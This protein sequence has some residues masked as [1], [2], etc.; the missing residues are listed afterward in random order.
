MQLLPFFYLLTQLFK[1]CKPVTQFTHISTTRCET[2]Q[3][4]LLLSIEKQCGM[5]YGVELGMISKRF[6]E[7]P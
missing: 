2:R 3:N 6:I 7:P 5:L 1:P 4:C